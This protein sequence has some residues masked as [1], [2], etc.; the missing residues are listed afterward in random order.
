MSQGSADAAGL[1]SS[2]AVLQRATAAPWRASAS[3][4][5]PPLRGRCGGGGH[6]GFPAAAVAAHLPAGS[7]VRRYLRLP[8][9]AARLVGYSVLNL[10]A[11]LISFQVHPCIALLCAK[12][13][14]PNRFGC[15]TVR[16]YWQN[17]GCA[18]GHEPIACGNEI[19]GQLAPFVCSVAHE[20]V[21]CC[22]GPGRCIASPWSP[23]TAGAGASLGGHRCRWW[24]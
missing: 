16:L 15:S 10:E 14:P 3:R 9:A 17:K 21:L 20:F 11:L 24:P 19:L 5:R 7:G 13:L 18:K 22:S 4:R 2:A 8:R 23:A 12:P 6:S 1:R